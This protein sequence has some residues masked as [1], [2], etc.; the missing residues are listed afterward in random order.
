MKVRIIVKGGCVQRVYVDN[1]NIIVELVDYDNM[2]EIA[3]ETDE[4]YVA[5]LATTYRKNIT[6][7][8]D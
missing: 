3:E 7:K 2:D 5:Q 6:N 4:M 8:E 1:R